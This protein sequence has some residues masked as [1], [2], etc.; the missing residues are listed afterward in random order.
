MARIVSLGS[1][2]QDLYL[3]DRDDFAATE[4]CD[5]GRKNCR[6]VFGELIIGSKVDIDRIMYEVGGGGTNSAVEFARHGHESIY[7]G[8][9]GRDSAGEAVLACLDEEGVDNSYVEH[10]AHRN[11]GCSVILLDTKSGERT[12]LT[13]RGA[14]SKFD[15]LDE[16]DLERIQP[17]W[18]YATS[19]RGDMDTLLRFFEKA[20]EIGCKVMFNP[21]K[22]ELAEKKKMIGLLDLVDVLLVNK[23][24][25]AE[26]VPGTV[27]SELVS[28][29]GN[30]VKTVIITDGNM[31]AIATDG[32]KTYRFGIYE[33][34]PVKD[35][36]GAG[37][38]FGSGFLAHLAN[39]ESFKK[40]LVYASANST[41]VVADFSAK[42]G[43]LRGNEKLHEMPIQE[44]K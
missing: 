7:L 24:E 30:Y 15:N 20:K 26:I 1:A 16:D 38:A 31:G 27:L 10:A 9:I 29:L 8:N 44:V 14:S 40:S 6:S 21:G 33:D 36:T 22:L 37:D 5:V 18:L 17:D 13:Y 19:L 28:R 2:L 41:A 39:G 23:S 25:A 11:T 4:F 3:I 42:K 12:I 43:L 34:V 35:T 32:E